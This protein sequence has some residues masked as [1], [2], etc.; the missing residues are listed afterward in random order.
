M[1]HTHRILSVALVLSM[2]LSMV[3]MVAAQTDAAEIYDLRVNDLVAPLGIDENP[4]FSWKMK[5]DAIGAA[6]T[7]YAITV[8][9]GETAVWNSGWVEDSDSTNIPYAGDSLEAS[10]AYTV[11]VKVKD[12]NGRETAPVETTFE[13][14]LMDE[15]F[16]DAQWISYSKD[17]SVISNTTKFAIDYDLT[18]H[19]GASG[20][21]FGV[22]D[23][24]N[25]VMW[26]FRSTDTKTTL[27]PHFKVSGKWSKTEYDITSVLGAGL[28]GKTLHQRI[29][30][31]GAETKTYMGESADNMQLVCTYTHTGD[32]SLKNLGIRHSNVD[33]ASYDNVVVTDALGDVIFSEDFSD[34]KNTV[35]LYG[36][37]GDHAFV[38][39][40]ALKI[41]APSNVGEHIYGLDPEA[42][43]S[44]TI[45][46]DF[47]MD[48][49][50]QGFSFGMKH[51]DYYMLW[52]VNAW[53][54]KDGSKAVLLRPHLRSN[55]AWLDRGTLSGSLLTDADITDAI[56]YDTDTI[57][58]K[59]I[60]ERI[61][62]DGSNIKTY[63]GS[64]ENNLKLAHEL[65]YIREIPL[66]NVGF[67][68]C[69]SEADG[70]EI[71]RYDN[72]R[73]VDSQGNVIYAEDFSDE[74]EL[75]GKSGYYAF[76]DGMLE[77]GSTSLSTGSFV[78]L[79]ARPDDTASNLPAYRRS[80][81]PA[82]EVAS[83]KLYTSG[84]GV[85][86]SYINGQ[87]VGRLTDEGVS[88]DE[89]TPGATQN[90]KRMFYNAYDVT[91]MLAEGEN[92][93]S[94]VVSSGWWS[95]EIV[96]NYGKNTAYL[97][98]L[99]LNYT[100]GT[101]ETIVTDTTTWKTARAAAMQ[102]GTG[103][104]AGERYDARV[105]QSWMLPGFDAGSWELPVENNEF[106][107]VVSA[108]DGIGITV[109]KDLERTP[110][111]IYI[112][113][114]I[115][116]AADGYYGT[117][118][119][120]ASYTDGDS[121]TV[122]PGE[123]LVVDFGQNFA[124]WEA[125]EFTAE[126]NTTIHVEHGEMLN[127]G[128]GAESR[129]CDGPEGSVYN[130][131]YRGISCDTIYITDAG[132]RYHP[133]HTFYGF[134]YIEITVDKPVTFTKLRGQVVTS[135]QDDSGWITTSDKDVNQLVSNTR[136]GMY[137]NYLSI[138]MDCPQRNER[139]GWTN[140]TVNFAEAG[141]YLNF[142]KS[143][144]EKW[145]Q[146]MRDGQRADGAYLSAAPLGHN[147]R[148]YGALGWADAGVLVPYILYYMY[149]DETIITD[150]W[151]SM[152]LFM[153]NYM[154]GTDGLG[155]TDR[156]GDWLSYESNDT[157]IKRM[158]GISYFAWDALA[159]A[160]MAEVIGDAE[161]AAHYKGVYEE[162]KAL[163]Q[164]L[165]VLEDGSLKRGEQSPCLYA[166]Y[167]DLLPNEESVAKVTEQLIS[168]IERNGN[169][170]QTG[171]LGTAIINNALSD[172]DRTDVAY[173]LLLQHDNPSWLYS[174]DQGATTI[175]ERWNSY[176]KE[177][178]I[179][180]SSMN[181]FNHYS[182]GCV[183]SW[184][185]R[186]M[187]GIGWDLD[188][189]GFQ[190]IILAP[191]PDRSLPE[192]E[193]AYD[194]PYGMI[195]SKSAFDGTAWNFEATLPANTTATVKIPVEADD[196]TV[197][198]NGKAVEALTLAEDGLVYTGTEGNTL[199]FDAVA[200]TFSV[201]TERDGKILAK[202]NAYQNSAVITTGNT[203][204]VRGL[205]EKAKAAVAAYE[206]N[207]GSRAEL[208]QY[209]YIAG[210]EMSL[211]LQETLNTAT[212]YTIDFDFAIENAAQGFCFHMDDVNNYFLW[213]INA[214]NNRNSSKGVLL[215]PHVMS[216]GSWADRPTLSGSTLVDTDISAALGYDTDTIVN[217]VIH[218]RVV[219]NGTHVQFW[220]GPD[221]ENLTLAYEMDYIREMPL[222]HLGVRHS[223]A[224][225]GAGVENG[226]YD[227]F[228]VTD[229]EGNVIY[230]EDFSD[231]TKVGYA[232][233]GN[234]S[235][236]S[237]EDGKLSIHG[238]TAVGAADAFVLGKI[239]DPMGAAA[240]VDTLIDAIDLENEETLTAA[241][242]AYDA[243]LESVQ[244]FVTKLAELEAAEKA[245]DGEITDVI[246][247]ITGPE[248][249]QA[250]D[251]EVT[252]TLS[253]KDMKQLANMIVTFEISE[254][255]LTDPVVTAAEGWNILAKSWKD[256]KLN[257]ALYNLTG[258]S[259]EGDI[260]SV[261]LKIADAEG[262]AS[263]ALTYAELVAY[264]GEGEVFV[265]ADLEGA[266]VT[267]EVKRNPFD[268]NKDGVVDQLD[269]T[270]CQR[271]YGKYHEDAD[272]DADGDVDVTDVIL[273][274]LHYNEN[275]RTE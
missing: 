130:K 59:L 137:S 41:A 91:W 134:R 131:N 13:T 3:P 62:V 270:R 210:A 99:V 144:L 127:D 104:Y 97:A 37:N 192:V 217:A 78:N 74:F 155:G 230:A 113:E 212:A 204:T 79:L 107:G 128:N 83:A 216:N 95:G 170:L 47:I 69:S 222:K 187:A 126:P 125:M 39:N 94:A 242:A 263:I 116:G 145:M 112:Y 243:L 68:H 122:N 226:Y 211:H 40:G 183:V 24:N 38:E 98:K 247:T 149:G 258:A 266:S 245:L 64:D 220:F 191:Q 11:T 81:T 123:T 221:E 54:Q 213:Q 246:L 103:I 139:S 132:T 2:L 118:I 169:K 194:S 147:G 271:Y 53:K 19:K 89:L 244:E 90:N 252:Y 51:T 176:T 76:R 70:T 162:E 23:S 168:N 58:G 55:G 66:D 251:E 44:Y 265:N 195:I 202:E 233:T 268:V 35:L 105:D 259:G 141:S 10:T 4:S 16:G 178:G 136:W 189:P 32:L 206:A 154:A 200:C 67:R 236:I 52:Q 185:F 198:V 5:S 114:G 120:T 65:N 7:A 43:L 45:D 234:D 108:W 84:L 121:V 80:F 225:N 229:G 227:N 218:Q 14:G 110:K 36:K 48:G 248:T 49:S 93:L 197:T 274:L 238:P 174:V 182:F 34:G 164:S 180:Q 160:Y 17:D 33:S 267:T 102:E 219:V 199:V 115:T 75:V 269:M 249:I 148:N 86:T 186:D 29:E 88:Y 257:V 101:S 72:L 190:H 177:G 188:N 142:S 255:Y 207:G 100:D 158:M 106:V 235:T 8:S 129:G 171:F 239:A 85:Y 31:D 87:R 231:P 57:I 20:F 26:Q 15:G 71:S 240:E 151:D 21:G 161:A 42:I 256:G 193:A 163:F 133:T 1:K 30:V 111:D 272:V 166:L 56:G 96:L 61:V 146:D 152:R 153:D 46:F 25:M 241:R 60:H 73:V 254:E 250:R 109:R 82:K 232:R 138:P 27:T 172:I 124:G 224:S 92:V 167:L 228:R 261:T 253:G 203:E 179:M 119:K 143:F 273:I 181:S 135:V 157:E 12:Q 77:V 214:W 209:T 117:V 22:V 223:T 205:V 9:D 260:L 208:E 6:Q 237:M 156:Y 173:K 50:A 275:F 184:M 150:N 159:M 165:Y 201:R 175:W 28:I 215:R 196:C 264:A 63:F 140:D 262:E 18:L